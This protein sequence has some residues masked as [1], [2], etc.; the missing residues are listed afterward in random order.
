MGADNLL[1]KTPVMHFVS[2][3]QAEKYLKEWQRRLFIESWFI[4]VKLVKGSDI[5]GSNGSND[6]CLENKICVISIATDI[7]VG[8]FAVKVPNE[9]TL[10]H[11][12]LHCKY[13]L[14]T[15]S[16]TYEGKTVELI[17]HQLIEEMSK[18][19]IMAK[20]NLSQEWFKNY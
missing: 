19:L 11:E 9:Q 13:G 18:S 12:L 1:F 2:Q 6:M 16:S 10:V 17:E 3:K 5:P 8:Y 20:Y 7:P 15:N 14:L 4:K